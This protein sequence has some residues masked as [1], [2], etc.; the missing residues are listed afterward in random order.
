[1][2]K[3]SKKKI[4]A[5][6]EGKML[7]LKVGEKLTKAKLSKY[8]DGDVEIN[9]AFA[10]PVLWSKA[11]P[12]RSSF[13]VERVRINKDKTWKSFAVKSDTMRISWGE[14][15]INGVYRRMNPSMI[16]FKDIPTPTGRKPK[17]EKPKAKKSKSKKSK[18][19]KKK[20]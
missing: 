12:S 20:V 10:G 5:K 19:T 2:A 16:R 3:K 13:E 11:L 15:V 17:E 14:G 4:P 7:S 18:R 8:W 6:S 9:P 1:M